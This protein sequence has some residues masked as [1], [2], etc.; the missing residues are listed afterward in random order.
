M[1]NIY[2]LKDP[3][4]NDIRYVGKSDNPDKR[5]LSHINE[6]RNNTYKENWIKRKRFIPSPIVMELKEK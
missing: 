4:T 5:Y 3:I 6:N 2:I 1:T